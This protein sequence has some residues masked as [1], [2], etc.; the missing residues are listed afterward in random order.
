MRIISKYAFNRMCEEFKD[1]IFEI[2]IVNDCFSRITL[3]TSE[4]IEYVLYS[5]LIEIKNKEKS[6]EGPNWVK[7]PSEN[8]DNPWIYE[9]INIID[10]ICLAILKNESIKYYVIC[11]KDIVISEIFEEKHDIEIKV[12]SYKLSSKH[13]II[14][15]FVDGKNKNNIFEQLNSEQEVIEWIDAPWDIDFLDKKIC[16]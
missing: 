12:R 16:N 7:T 1:K 13:F 15:V 10:D 2:E 3:D 11:Y 14:E 9:E 8:I 4:I 6:N 5:E